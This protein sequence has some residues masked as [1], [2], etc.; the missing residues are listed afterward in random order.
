[1]LTFSIP[2]L[3]NANTHRKTPLEI[4]S[5][6][7]GNKEIYCIFKTCY[8]FSVSFSAKF[9]LFHDFIFFCSNNP[10]VFYKPC[11]IIEIVSPGSIRVKIA[12]SECTHNNTRTADWFF[13]KFDFREFYTKNIFIIHSFIGMCRM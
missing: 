3:P 9:H 8:I 4:Y 6:Y 2:M 10:Q 1:M 7:A 5:I 13:M 12:L 11:P